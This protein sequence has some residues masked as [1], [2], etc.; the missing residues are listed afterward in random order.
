M[1]Q[2]VG[3]TFAAFFSTVFL[4]MS[5]LQIQVADAQT[6][7]L[8]E[9]KPKPLENIPASN[10]QLAMMIQLRPH[11]ENQAMRENG[12]YQVLGW[13]LAISNP[14][15]V[16]PSQNCVFD[17]Q[18][19]VMGPEFISPGERILTGKLRINSGGTTMI[20]DFYADWAAVEE[21]IEGGQ[22]VQVIEGKLTLGTDRFGPE[23]RYQING[24]LTPYG[25]D[26]LLAIQGSEN[27]NN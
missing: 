27:N 9:F 8:P 6:I 4:T 21:H 20:R 17:L 3:Y 14:S 15:E 1:S 11:T 16:C 18:G 13:Q 22:I 24:T 5:A 7:P 25:Q 23:N 12:Y 19:G 10:D 26:L 2:S